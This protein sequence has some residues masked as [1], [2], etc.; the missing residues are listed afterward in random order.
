MVYESNF[1]LNSLRHIFFQLCKKEINV[2]KHSQYFICFV[3]RSA[4][5]HLP[6][7]FFSF[8]PWQEEEK[9]GELRSVKYLPVIM[10]VTRDALIEMPL[11]R[12]F[13]A[14]R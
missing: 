2:L 1:Y 7:Q 4:H 11:L 9:M 12:Y 14:P 10:P 5:E 6:L 8:L 13:K 3:R